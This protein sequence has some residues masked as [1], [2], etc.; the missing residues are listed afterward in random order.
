MCKAF[1][2]IQLFAYLGDATLVGHKLTQFDHPIL[3]R[4]A[5]DLGLRFLPNDLLDTCALARRLLPHEPA[6][7][8]ALA[9]RF[10]YP[11]AQT[12]PAAADVQM[13]AFVLEH[14]LDLHQCDQALDV[15]D[16]V[17][18][19]VAL[20]IHVSGVPLIDENALLAQAGTRVAAA[21]RDTSL[22]DRWRALVADAQQA[23]LAWRAVTGHPCPALEED[24]AWQEMAARWR[25][26]VTN[27]EHYCADHSLPSFL[28]YARLATVVDDQFDPTERVTLMTMH[29]AK[30]LEWSCVFLVGVEDGVFPSYR[31]QTE[32]ERA[33]DGRVLYVGMTRAQQH[34]CISWSTTT[35]GRSRRPS[36][37]LAAVPNALMR[38]YRIHGGD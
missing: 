27:F 31:S 29:A 22:Q 15:L 24:T 26:M 21:A 20:G 32:G 36:P 9:Q 34:L 1:T 17:L 4:L 14:V 10:G 38:H 25:A 5:A 11:Q 8:A 28:H 33:E 30:G 3:Y 16:E 6:A 35:D 7:L 19:L 18:P 13:T 37:F 12:H 2:S 23:T